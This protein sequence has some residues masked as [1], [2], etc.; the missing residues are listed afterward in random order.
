MN[1]CPK[2]KNY[3]YGTACKCQPFRCGNEEFSGED[4][5]NW[6][7]YH[8]QDHE[9]AAEQWAEYYDQDDHHLLEN[10]DETVECEVIAADGTVKKFKVG[11]EIE[12]SYY[13]EEMTE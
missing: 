7:V 4:R 1:R 11:G 6:R 10:E 9:T 2:C 5:A 13:A 12:I 3:C 8:A